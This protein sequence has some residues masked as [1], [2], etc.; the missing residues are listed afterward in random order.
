MTFIILNFLIFFFYSHFLKQKILSKQILK[1]FPI[2]LSYAYADTY[3]DLNNYTAILGDSHAFGLSDSYL[4]NKYSYSVGHYL[5][6]FFD[7]KYNFANFGVPGA[8]SELILE[9]FKL[10]LKRIKQKPDKIIYF[11]Y[12]GNDLENNIKYLRYPEIYQVSEIRKKIKYYF[13]LVVVTKRLMNNFKYEIKNKFYKKNY[14][15][16][17]E[18]DKNYNFYKVNE[19]RFK[20]ATFF[21]SPP[22]ELNDLEIQNSLNI[23]FDT[24]SELK[25]SIVPEIYIVYIVV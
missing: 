10:S 9:K 3:K 22:L 11:F 12:E 18:Q 17:N 13:P 16:K 21:Q 19:K 24:L 25:N 4:E 20:T 6:N 2:D 15:K 23:L 5:F 7:Y 1:L 14:S 8:G